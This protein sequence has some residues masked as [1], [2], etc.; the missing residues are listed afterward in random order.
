MACHWASYEKNFSFGLCPKTVLWNLGEFFL[1]AGM[2]DHWFCSSLSSVEGCCFS[3][4]LSRVCLKK[5]KM[6]C[7]RGRLL[8]RIYYCSKPLQR[9]LFNVG[10]CTSIHEN[11]SYHDQSDTLSVFFVECSKQDHSDPTPRGEQR[12]RYWDSL[13]TKVC[14]N[15]SW[16]I[17]S[18][19]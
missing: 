2:K 10:L 19:S 5:I 7:R 9:L 4:K 14:L 11:C 17:P 16:H 13:K 8:I 18:R 15:T 6:V 12:G 3:C 1:S